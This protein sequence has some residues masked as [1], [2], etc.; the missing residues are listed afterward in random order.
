MQLVHFTDEQ[1]NNLKA[2]LIDH[3]DGF[4]DDQ[5]KTVFHLLSVNRFNDEQFG[6]FVDMLDTSTQKLVLLHAGGGTGITFV[7]CKIFK[8]PF[9]MKFVVAG[10]Q[11]GLVHYTYHKAKLSTV[12]S[13]HG[14]QV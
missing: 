3:R 5:S 1:W 14:H 11:P 8:A 6:I 9:T 12:F 7:T 2:I 10:V 4:T 13:G